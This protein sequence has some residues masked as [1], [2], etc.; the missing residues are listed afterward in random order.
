[1]GKATRISIPSICRTVPVLA[2]SLLLGQLAGAQASIAQ[3]DPSRNDAIAAEITGKLL[4]AR[5]IYAESFGDDPINKTLQSMIIDTLRTS[6]RFIITENR[7]KADL[8]LKGAALEKTSQEFHSLGSSTAVASA[9]GHSNGSISGNSSSS[10]YGNS[11]SVSGSSQGS[12][13]GSS[14]GGFIAGASSIDDAQAS[15]ETIN[16]A[17]VAVRLVSVDGDVVWSTTQESRGAKYK[18][19]TADAADKIVKQLL[20]DL[21]KLDGTR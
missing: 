13:S 21:A 2:A 17:R 16:D 10:I 11:R 14:H 8:F 3:P 20:R 19:S 12:L 6:S 4:K 1:V 18:S 15:T 7:E 5:R 9:A